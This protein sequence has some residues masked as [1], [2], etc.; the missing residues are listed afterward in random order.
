MV[1]RRVPSVAVATI[2]WAAVIGACSDASPDAGAPAPSSTA[3]TTITESSMTVPDA[4]STVPGG[5]SST[6]AA[7]GPVPESINWT[8]PLIG[9][10]EIDMSGFRDRGVML[11]FWAPY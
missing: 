7:T 2:L 1:R 11:W 8:A 3:G 6:T 9:G 10:G 5:E 4:T